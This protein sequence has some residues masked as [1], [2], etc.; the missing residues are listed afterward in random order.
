LIIEATYG[1]PVFR[2][3][4][5]LIWYGDI[6]APLN[7]KKLINKHLENGA[8]SYLVLAS[9]YKVPVGIAELDDNNKVIKMVE[10][11]WL[12]LKATIGILTLNREVLNKDIDKELGTHFDIMGNLIPYLIERGYKVYG[13]KYYGEWYDIGSLERYNKLDHNRIHEIINTYQETQFKL[14]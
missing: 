3:G 5:S 4:E 1:D 13:Y 9:R 12:D 2:F 10:K 11:P 7:V 14:E 6:I 8:D